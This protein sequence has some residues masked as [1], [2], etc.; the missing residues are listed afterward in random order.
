MT[1]VTGE[2]SPDGSH[3]PIPDFGPEALGELEVM[4]FQACSLDLHTILPI[5]MLPDLRGIQLEIRD[6]PRVAVHGSWRDCVAVEEAQPRYSLHHSTR[7]DRAADTR[8]PQRD[9]S[10]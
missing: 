3:Q 10:C 4:V 1:A 7:L 9:W 2:N 6:G 8:S 5:L